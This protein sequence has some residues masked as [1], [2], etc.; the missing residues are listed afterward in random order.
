MSAAYIA[1]LFISVNRMFAVYF[2]FFS[3][4]N[5]NQRYTCFLLTV[6]ITVL[7]CVPTAFPFFYRCSQ[8][9]FSPHHYDIIPVGCTNTYDYDPE[10]TKLLLRIVISIW[11]FCTFAALTVDLVTLTKLFLYTALFKGAQKP[12]NYI[13][14]IRLFLQ[15]FILNVVVCAG[16]VAAHVLKE[17][18]ETQFTRFWFSQFQVMLGF[19]LNG[20]IP[21]LFNKALRNFW[22]KRKVSNVVVLQKK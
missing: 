21:L 14:N 12:S 13:Q 9:T 19:L 15:S 17:K 10:K 11:G 22:R 7:A 6:I 3:S 5:N 2:P 18:F 20:L 4:K 8:F 16:V 1:H